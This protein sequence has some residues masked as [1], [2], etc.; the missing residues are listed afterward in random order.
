LHKKLIP[1][2]K[3]INKDV[4]GKEDDDDNDY[5][6][7]NNDTIVHKDDYE[8][9]DRA[10]PEEEGGGSDVNKSRVDKSMEKDRNVK[11]GI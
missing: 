5:E 9:F 8:E 6:F 4:I 7:T 10:E 11:K 1:M 2:K 3:V